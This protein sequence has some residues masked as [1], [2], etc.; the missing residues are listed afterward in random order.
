MVAVTLFLLVLERG[1]QHRHSSIPRYGG[2]PVLF[3]HLFWFYS[4]PAVYIMI[5]P[6]MGIVSDGDHHDVSARKKPLRIHDGC[7][8]AS[9]GDCR[10]GFPGVGAT[11]CSSAGI[12]M[13]A[14]DDLLC[15]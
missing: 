13:Y 8:L 6:S 2:D 10:P 4:H 12:S 14:G 7:V 5:L 9:F 1:L 3:Q 11:T 15:S